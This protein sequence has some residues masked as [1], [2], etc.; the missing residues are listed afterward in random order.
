MLRYFFVAVGLAIVSYLVLRSAIGVWILPAVEKE[1]ARDPAFFVPAVVSMVF[2]V[3]F[4]RPFI[5][6]HSFFGPVIA[7]LL[8]PFLVGFFFTISLTIFG[9]SSSSYFVETF[10]DTFALLRGVPFVAMESL[11]VTVPLAGVVAF[12]LRRS[13]PPEMIKRRNLATV[14]PY[15]HS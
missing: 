13:D 1:V 5:R 14:D 2:G 15:Q 10:D 7:S 3:F 4:L 8:A 11:R 12:L 6:A 9:G